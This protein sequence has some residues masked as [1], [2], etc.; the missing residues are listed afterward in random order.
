M[1]FNRLNYL[2]GFCNKT[3]AHYLQVLYYKKAGAG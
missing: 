3:W 2:Y 1:A